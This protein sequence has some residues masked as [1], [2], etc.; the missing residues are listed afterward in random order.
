M[1][2]NPF[3][4]AFFR[5]TISNQCTPITDYILLVP[6]TEALL[7]SRDRESNQLY[8][9]LVLSEEFL[10]SHVIRAPRDEING[11]VIAAAREN[12]GKARQYST[13][14]GRT[15]IIKDTWVYTN[16]GPPATTTIRRSLRMPLIS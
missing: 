4:R 14:N 9:D 6:T 12:R 7:H 15:V 2:L 1:P 5:S 3:L 16:K 13:S 8:T 11:A 10:G